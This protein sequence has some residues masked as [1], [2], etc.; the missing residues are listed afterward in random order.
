MGN[1]ATTVGV[2]CALGLGGISFLVVSEI[3][4]RSESGKPL[5][6]RAGEALACDTVP[7][8]LL[9]VSQDAV[10]LFEYSEKHHT[11]GRSAPFRQDSPGL[12]PS[13]S[14]I[15]ADTERRRILKQRQEGSP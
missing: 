11:Y 12:T 15:S 7:Q 9:V 2:V 6:I 1:F 13:L 14:D 3:R 5:I 4:K 10:Y 8:K